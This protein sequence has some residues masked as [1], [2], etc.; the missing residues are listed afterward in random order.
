M[1]PGR[2]SA[3]AAPTLLQPAPWGHGAQGCRSDSSWTS[4]DT[5][6]LLMEPGVRPS[7]TKPTLGNRVSETPQYLL[8]DQ[9][10]QRREHFPVSEVEGAV[11]DCSKAEHA[12]TRPT[13]KLVAASA[14]QSGGR[15]ASLGPWGAGCGLQSQKC[16]EEG[17][18]RPQPSWQ[19]SSCAGQEADPPRQAASPLQGRRGT[20]VQPQLV[21]VTHKSSH[22]FAPAL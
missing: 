5:Q 7:S 4:G 20:D 10:G 6:A 17:P 8:L 14:T 3:G 15:L 22:L 11:T 12:G 1:G 9:N 2:V 21:L 19:C 18:T 13:R 16:P